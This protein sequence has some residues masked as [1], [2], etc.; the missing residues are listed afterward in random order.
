MSEA[1]FRLR[2]Q[3]LARRAALLAAS[4]LALGA[5][6]FTEKQE[7]VQPNTCVLDSDCGP[8]SSCQAGICAMQSEAGL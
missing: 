1:L 7:E 3:I 2:H 8:Q 6:G 5:C 4:A